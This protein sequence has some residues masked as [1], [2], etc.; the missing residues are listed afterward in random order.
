[1]G[2]KVDEPQGGS[3]QAF[4]FGQTLEDV[5]KRGGCGHIRLQHLTSVTLSKAIENRQTMGSIISKDH[6]LTCHQ[7]KSG[8]PCYSFQ[9]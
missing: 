4:A 3:D 1:M 7:K 5:C 2:K 6:C 9:E 8:Y